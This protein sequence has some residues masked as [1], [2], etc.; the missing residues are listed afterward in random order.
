[1]GTERISLIHAPIYRDLRG[2]VGYG[3]IGIGGAL[4][5]HDGLVNRPLCRR[6]LEG[7]VAISA[8]APSKVE[9][10]FDRP[11]RILG[12][13]NASATLDRARPIEFWANHNYVGRVAE[14][15]ECTAEATVEAGPCILQA[16]CDG[17]LATGRHSVWAVGEADDHADVSSGGPAMASRTA[18]VVIGAFVQEDVPRR[19]AHLAYSARRHGIWLH[20]R[21]VGEPYASFPTKI[22]RTRDWI[23]NLPQQYSHVL[24]V[25]STDVLLARPLS[26]I[27]SVFND[28]GASIVASAEAISCPV[29]DPAWRERFT[30]HPD[31]RR[32][33]NA[34]MWMGERTAVLHAMDT[35]IALHHEL[36]RSAPTPQL[37]DVWQW[38][39]WSC[40]DQFM[41][42]LALLKNLFPLHLD[43]DARLFLNVA[44]M[45][46]RLSGNS[47]CTLDPVSGV[48]A[49]KSNGFRPA[50]LHFSGSANAHCKQQWAGYLGLAPP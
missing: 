47:Q 32:W 26:E 38:R 18:V 3:A 15:G 14:P 11:V 29:L 6:C 7:F 24:Y 33:L 34:G 9:L 21:G 31:N 17:S 25:D 30:P 20:V 36:Q 44:T 1:M 2:S 35:M 37:E 28:I 16:T 12:F 43:R 22:V 8:H 45:D 39:K 49:L 48:V 13:L 42:Q 40:R 10:T 41:W 19:L 4:G 23:Q 5:F 46:R 27:C 50:V